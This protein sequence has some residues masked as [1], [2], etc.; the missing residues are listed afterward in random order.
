MSTPSERLEATVWLEST[1]PD[2]SEE[3]RAEFYSA[4]DAYYGEH[5]ASGRD[6]DPLSMIRQDDH[7]FA[8]ILRSITNEDPRPTSN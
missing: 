6:L 4:V 7:A 1:F 8:A 2:L 3:H 5:P